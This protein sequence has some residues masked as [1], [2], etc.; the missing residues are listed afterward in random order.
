MTFD[1]PCLKGV[2]D[3][4]SLIAGS[5]LFQIYELKLIDDQWLHFLLAVDLRISHVSALTGA[6]LFLF[7][8]LFI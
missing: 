2:S 6:F 3:S 8:W 5:N 4:A 7:V 1:S